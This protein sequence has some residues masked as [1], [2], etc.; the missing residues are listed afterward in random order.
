MRPSDEVH[1]YPRML[2][3]ILGRIASSSLCEENKKAVLEFHDH[4]IADGLSLARQTKYLETLLLIGK[5]INGNFRGLTRNEIVQ[6]V[7]SI[8]I[9][10]YSDWTKHD[11]KVI[12]KIF[13]RWLKDSRVYP[14]EVAWIRVRS[15]GNG[16]L[17]EELVSKQD[18]D[19]L[20][21]VAYTPRD[22][23]LVL[24]LFE[25]GC[26]IGEILSLRVKNISF[27]QHGAQLIVRGK[28]GARRVR[29]I[30]SV[31]ALSIWMDN[32]PFRQNPDAPLWISLGTRDRGQMLTYSAA[33]YALRNLVKRA[34]LTKRIYPHL[35]RHSR[36]TFLAKHLND[37]LLKQHFGWTQSTK[38]AAKYVHLSGR[39]VDAELLRLQGVVVD[40]KGREDEFK[41]LTCVRC[42]KTSSPGSRY[43][44]NCGL[45]LDASSAARVDELKQK[46]D[47][48][49]S[50]LIGNEDVLDRLLNK[51]DEL[52][53]S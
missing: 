10:D 46:A 35:F 27:D 41:I 2:K 33:L 16:I 51:V 14:D 1:N 19:K 4:L 8:E 5:R 39:E 7:K 53:S 9:S 3:N 22:R 24:V 6:F 45:P 29:I 13:Y 31:P 52:R 28:T 15:G 25:S 37:A 49:I 38:M 42:S 43:C 44:N 23:A 47:K 21:E 20:L 48:L 50:V 34:G 36:A 17:P 12:F 11:Y 32:H 26:R 40:Q 18:V 30:A